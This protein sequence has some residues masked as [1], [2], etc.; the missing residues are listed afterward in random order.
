VKNVLILNLH[1]RYEGIAEGALN[2]RIAKEAKRY[3]VE[4]GCDAKE[5][6]IE[7]GYDLAAELQKLQWA[8]TIFVQSPV[9]WMGLPWMAKKYVDEIFSG[10]AGTVTYKHD[11]RPAGGA[12]G[13]GGLMQSKRY[14]LSFTYN[15]PESEF[16]NPDGFFE[17][18]DIDGTNIALHKTFMFCGARPL[19][20]FAVHDV[21]SSFDLETNLQRL[22][23]ILAENF[24]S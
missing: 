23:S 21:Y 19:R 8:D 22:R 11:G 10:G 14:M 13:S 5:T 6:V 18:L 16:S 17:G 2:A 3:F 12:Y 1:Q 20:S 24:T 15:C 7:T 9:Y 4:N